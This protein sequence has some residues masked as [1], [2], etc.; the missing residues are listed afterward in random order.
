MTRPTC[1][2]P[3]RIR[4]EPLMKTNAAGLAL[5][6]EFEGFVPTWYR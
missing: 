6:K 5:I 2:R 4:M 3:G 1:K